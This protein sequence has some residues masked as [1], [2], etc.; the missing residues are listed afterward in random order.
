MVRLRED[1]LPSL[2]IEHPRY[3][4]IRVHSAASRPRMVM[5]DIYDWVVALQAT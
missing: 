1:D 4:E 2:G 3:Q 5:D